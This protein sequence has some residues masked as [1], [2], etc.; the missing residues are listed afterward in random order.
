ME[1]GKDADIV[2]IGGRAMCCLHLL[3]NGFQPQ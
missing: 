1:H 2:V 3:F